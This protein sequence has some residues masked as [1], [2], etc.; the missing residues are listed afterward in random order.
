MKGLRQFLFFDWD[1][2]AKGKIFAVTGVSSWDDN[3]TK[4]HVGT[5]VECAI[6]DDKTEYTIPKDGNG[7][8]NK[9]Q[10]VKFKIRKDVNLPIDTKVIPQGVR[11]SVYGEYYNNLSIECADLGIVKEQAT[12]AK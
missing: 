11:A 8:T 3:D 5:K 4:A 2:F 7:F 6:I 9:Y 1:A 10:H 12:S